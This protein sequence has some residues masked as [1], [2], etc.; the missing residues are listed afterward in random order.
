MHT[1][2]N[3]TGESAQIFRREGD[4]RICIACDD[5]PSGLRNS[6]PT[7]AVLPMHAGAAAQ[8]LLAWD[9]PER[10]HQVLH[11]AHFNASRLNEV[12]KRGWA[13]SVNENEQGVCSIAAPIRNATGQVMA[14]ISISGP[15]ERMSQAPGRHYAPLVMAAG[16]YLS[17]ALKRAS[18]GLTEGKGSS[19]L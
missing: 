7:G 13:E 3:R 5:R 14:A 4:H 11:H 9:A 15:L 19:S 12:R 1:L 8:I 2:R 17:D 6:I 18:S 16:R 10:I